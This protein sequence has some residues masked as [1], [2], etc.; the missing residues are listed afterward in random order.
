MLDF[1]IGLLLLRFRGKVYN[2]ILVI[3][4]RYIK[5]A[6]YILIIKEINAAELVELFLLYIIKDFGILVGIILDRGL[7]FTS[8]F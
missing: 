5:I 4:N 1:I 8:K 7:V 2:L 3:V 6:Y